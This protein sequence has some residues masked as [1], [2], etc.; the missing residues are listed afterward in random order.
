MEAIL[1]GRVAIEMT[2]NADDG[3]SR[4]D[5][6]SYRSELNVQVQDV[7][8]GSFQFYVGGENQLGAVLLVRTDKSTITCPRSA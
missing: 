5:V 2:L 4:Y 6:L 7:R 8:R 3:G 1:E